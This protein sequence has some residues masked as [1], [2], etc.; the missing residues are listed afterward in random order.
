MIYCNA[1][2]ADEIL[3]YEYAQQETMNMD[4]INELLPKNSEAHEGISPES[5]KSFENLK[6]RPKLRIWRS[7]W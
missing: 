6:N 4:E 3:P 7:F 1:F 2:S 5:N